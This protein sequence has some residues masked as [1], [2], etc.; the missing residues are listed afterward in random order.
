MI[1]G[2]LIRLRIIMRTRGDS[3]N[4]KFKN[5]WFALALSALCSCGE[6]IDRYSIA[7]EIPAPQSAKLEGARVLLVDMSAEGLDNDGVIDET[8]I[9]DGRFTF[10]G[11][12]EHVRGIRLR[13][14]QDETYLYGTAFALEPGTTTIRFTDGNPRYAIESG[15]YT[16]F[17]TT[18]GASPEELAQQRAAAEVRRSASLVYRD[19]AATEEEKAA[20]AERAREIGAGLGERK[21]KRLAEIATS[22]PDPIK[23]LLAL[24]YGALVDNSDGVA[25][26]TRIVETLNELEAVLGPN[27]GLIGRRGY[28]EAWLKRKEEEALIVGHVA[29]D[30]SATSLAGEAVRLSD[31]LVQNR[32]V[33]V[34]FWASWCGPCLTQIPYLKEAYEEYGDKGFEILA[35]STDDERLEWEEASEEHDIP[36]INTSDEFGTESPVKSLYDIEAVP[37]N[38]LIDSETGVI[39]AQR[40]KDEQLSDM[41]ASLLDDRS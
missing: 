10:E 5:I 32:Y 30:F 7:G 29:S 36:W 6:P 35:F 19:P 14:H 18:W 20:A 38:F 34:E 8:T 37:A 33:L 39:I 40:L 11:E 41:L 2:R 27:P 1:R 28:N 9:T 17:L 15:P 21:M 16:E 4:V 31:V 23:R 24:Q 25:S 26:R 13:V 3:Q 22:D 12:A